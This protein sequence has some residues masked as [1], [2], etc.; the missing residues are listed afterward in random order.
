M[1]A[2]TEFG[3]MLPLEG[4]ALVFSAGISTLEYSSKPGNN[5]VGVF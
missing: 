1:A 2:L 5:G 4:A 3:N